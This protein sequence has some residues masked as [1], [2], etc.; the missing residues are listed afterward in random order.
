[1]KRT[2]TYP[3]HHEMAGMT[4]QSFLKQQQYSS[5]VI[6]H[7]KRTPDGICR[8]GVW[9]R[10]HEV[11][12][13]GDLLTI[14]IV[15]ETSSE[16]IVPV[17]LPFPIV[18]EDKDLLVIN[19]PS[20]MP[21]HPSQGNYENTLANAAAYYFASQNIPFTYR[22]INRLDRD[23]TGLLI[24]AK[25]MYSASL[26]SNMVARR[27]IHR[28]YLAAATGLVE[29]SGMIEAPIGRANGSTIVRFLRKITRNH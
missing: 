24:I 22:C 4:I 23:T 27:E 14:S 5:Q 25:H 13:S 6:T 9:A 19:K 29:E 2:F 26:L 17:P 7:L 21:I 28:E 18:Y 16:H 8:N 20:G 1:M 12:Q 15:E 10:V 3:I 11:L